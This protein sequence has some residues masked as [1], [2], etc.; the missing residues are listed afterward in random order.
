MSFVVIDRADEKFLRECFVDQ[1]MKYQ[2]MRSRLVRILDNYYFK[3]VFGDELRRCIDKAVTV[4]PR[5]NNTDELSAL[6]AKNQNLTLPQDG[7]QWKIWVR[8]ELGKDESVV[9]Y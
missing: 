4:V 8:A 3:E 7:F 1:L 5:L 9:V 2:R 6:I